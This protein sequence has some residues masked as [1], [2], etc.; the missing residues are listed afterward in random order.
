MRIYSHSS[1]GTFETC[2]RQYWYQYIGKPPVERV[3]TI[4]AFLGTCVHETLE[5][6]YRLRL[7]GRLLS[8]EEALEGFETIWAK[9][10]SD[11]IR[12][13]SEELKAGDY[14]R[15]GREALASYYRR[16][17]PLDQ[18]K[19]L[20]LEAKVTFDLDPRVRDHGKALDPR[21]RGDDEKRLDSRWSLPR[22]SIRGGDDA[23]ARSDEPPEQG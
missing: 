18:A 16:Y 10:W 20:R 5:A 6:L 4:E 17:A 11:T 12:I 3:D 9:G 15:A 2:P 23:K 8:E 1:L 14:K 22:T 7:R 19:T 13:V 21:V